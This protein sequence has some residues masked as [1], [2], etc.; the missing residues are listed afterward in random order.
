MNG[1]TF[2]GGAQAFKLDTLLKLAD[3]KGTDGKTTLLHFVVQEIIR[4]EG[5]CTAKAT[6]RSES[7]GLQVGSGLGNECEDAKKAAEIDADVLT[8]IVTKLGG[9]LLK[10]KE[11]FGL[12]DAR[13]RKKNGH[14]VQTRTYFV[15]HAKNEI[16]W[17]Q[18]EEK[19]MLS[20]LKGTTDYFHGNAANDE[21]LRPFIIVR[22]FLHMLDKACKG[23]M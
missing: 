16:T 14:F 2:H 3:A 17:L 11:I 21:G 23:S 8:S 13:H 4:S 7:L 10:N 9:M 5:V 12:R 22:D 20:L 1:G 19:M 6:S 15:E 18:S